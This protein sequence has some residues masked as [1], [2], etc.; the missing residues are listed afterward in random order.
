MEL[1]L[2]PSPLFQV[3]PIIAFFILCVS[4]FLQH[5]CLCTSR[6]PGT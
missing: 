6:V 1:Y 2:C 5:V 4:M 3:Q